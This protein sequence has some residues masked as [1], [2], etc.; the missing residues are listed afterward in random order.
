MM[1][2]VARR[3]RW[4]RL[5]CVV[6]LSALLWC[7]PQTASAWHGHWRGGWGF[8]PWCGPAF[9]PGFYGSG[10]YGPRFYGGFGGWYGGTRFA[11]TDSV[12]LGGTGG[13]FFSGT[14]RGYSFG[15]PG[16][17]GPVW[18]GYGWPACYP[19]Y[20]PY[21]YPY[22]CGWGWNPV[23]VPS[24]ITRW[25]APVYG[26]RPVMPWL[27]FAD[28]APSPRPA[29][30]AEPQQLMAAARPAATPPVPRF[31]APRQARAV[32]VRS[33]NGLARL[34]AGR[35]IAVGDRHLRTAVHEPTKLSAALDAYRRA[36]TTA[37]DLADTYLRQAF[38]LTALDRGADAT[39]AIERAIAVDP[40]LGSDPAAAVAARRELP[41]DPV[42]GERPDTGPTSLE[43]RGRDLLARIFT[44]PG[45]NA[46]L[47][48]PAPGLNWIA[49]RWTRLHG[50][51]A[52][53][54]RPD[55]VAAK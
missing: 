19:A 54:L 21:V 49:D 23:V 5:A 35:L 14:L 41:P 22:G 2:S 44:E 51:G 34:R 1:A 10:F 7:P 11:F 43:S 29:A 39:R 9:G 30:L 28:A 18:G 53:G 37:P 12:F 42:F 52:N 17:C 38:V 25:I 40:R 13:G 16:W 33:S 8:R 45:A 36:A 46:A 48:V 3:W 55:A 26:P 15:G 50:D 47:A 4:S 6:V 32:V 20:A 27:G 24:P 31:E